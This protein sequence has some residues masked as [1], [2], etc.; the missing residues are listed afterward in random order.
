MKLEVIFGKNERLRDEFLKL[1]GIEDSKQLAEFLKEEFQN[2]SL[3][4][5]PKPISGEMLFLLRGESIL[6]V[7]KLGSI[8]I[9]QTL[10]AYDW[11]GYKVS[12]SST[13]FETEQPEVSLRFSKGWLEYH[14]FE[15]LAKSL[16]KG[17][18][19]HSFEDLAKSL[20]T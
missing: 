4:M 14:S 13:I 17:W 2:D 8:P 12:L 1:Q 6:T 5:N 16:L 18:L 7:E 10:W 15:D 9:I 11:C 20:K 3:Q 19:D